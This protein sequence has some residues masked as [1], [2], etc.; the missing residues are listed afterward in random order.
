MSKAYPTQENEEIDLATL[1]RGIGS[2]FQ[3][4]NRFL[5]NTIQ[6]FIKNIIVLVI[7]IVVGVALGMYLDRS[8]SYDNTIVVMPNFESVDYFYSKID[9]LNSKIAERDTAFLKSIGIDE[10]RKLNKI[11]VKPV[12]DVYRFLNENDLNF[13]IFEL[14]AADSDAEKSINADA[15]S[16]NYKYHLITF[17]TN[18]KTSQQKTVDPIMKYLNNSPHFAKLQKTYNYNSLMKVKANEVIISQIDGVLNQLSKGP[19]SGS[20]SGNLIYNE[21]SQ[22]NDLIDSKD[23]LIREQGYLR[24]ALLNQDMI[25]KLSSSN[26]NV[27]N[28]ESISGKL[29]LIIP[30]ILILI[31]VAIINFRR[32]Y[33]KQSAAAAA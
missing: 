5:F 32:F 18:G 3:K 23:K 16:K 6:F 20:K 7:L 8:K 17:T 31:Y 22:L 21:N 30:L 29:K 2:G 25:I 4:F 19:D 33:K 24:I 13:K 14:L 28:K 10:P 12:V 1:K 15:T 9:L 11:S 26:L 27:V